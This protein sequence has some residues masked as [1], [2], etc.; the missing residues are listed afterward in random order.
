M[1]GNTS[2]LLH[3][4]SVTKGQHGLVAVR[5]SVLNAS[6]ADSRARCSTHK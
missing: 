4:S 2:E 1:A 5:A 6:E 3:A